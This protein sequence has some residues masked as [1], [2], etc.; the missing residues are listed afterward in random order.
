MALVAH[1]FVGSFQSDDRLT[2]PEVGRAP[3]RLLQLRRTPSPAARDGSAGQSICTVPGSA[4]VLGAD[5]CSTDQLAFATGA[6]FLS[7]GAV[8]VIGQSHCHRTYAIR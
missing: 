7:G 3:V 8:G 4:R 1:I 2:N 5:E 6:M